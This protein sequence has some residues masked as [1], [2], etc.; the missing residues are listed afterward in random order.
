MKKRLFFIFCG[1]MCLFLMLCSCGDDSG[2][3]ALSSQ[4][5]TSS[6]VLPDVPG[7]GGVRDD[8]EQVVFPPETDCP[9]TELGHYWKDVTI[10]RDTSSSGSVIVRGICYNCGDR[11][12]K[13][14]VSLV[15]REQWK[16]ALSE[17][18][19]KS[20]TVIMNNE[21]T[22]YDENGSLVWRIKNNVF[23]QDMFVNSEKNST[24]HALNYAGFL[25]AE[26]YNK[27]TY[28]QNSKTYVYNDVNSKIELGF[29]DGTLLYYSF[30]S[31][32]QDG[33]KSSAIYVN[34]GR[35]K[36]EAPFYLTSSF[37]RMTSLEEISK[38]TIS[39][40]YANS[41]YNALSTLSFDSKFEASYLEN[42]KI[43]VYFYLENESVD[44]IFGEKYSSVSVIFD[45][46]RLSSVSFGNNKIELLYSDNSIDSAH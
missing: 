9:A 28:D 33:A 21:Y 31:L 22:D 34:H 25:L 46:D 3:S 32:T 35:I 16:A 37:E 45:S 39:N 17:D 19:L 43:S 23:T 40:E 4:I 5:T 1:V 30:E 27:F 20:F 11:L 44:P 12:G 13:E 6:I 24:S 29:A 26:S 10:E 8:E 14:A 18:G 15:D 36:I 42:G 41:L 7:G 38:A 2:S